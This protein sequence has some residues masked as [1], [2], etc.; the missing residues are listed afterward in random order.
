MK[1]EITLMKYNELIKIII[2]STGE[3]GRDYIMQ[4]YEQ[5]YIV[6]ATL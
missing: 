4:L 1:T 5:E 2:K 6:A 3:E